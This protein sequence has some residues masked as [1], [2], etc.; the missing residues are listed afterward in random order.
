MRFPLPARA[1]GWLHDLAPRPVVLSCPYPVDECVRLLSVA[2]TDRGRVSW[3]LDPRTAVQP[4]PRFF[5]KAGPSGVCLARHE[6]FDRR[7]STPAWLSAQLE[8]AADG[9][10]NLAGTIGRNPAEGRREPLLFLILGLAGA[11]A[12]VVGS[13]ALAHGRFGG[14]VAI[15]VLPLAL[16]G[17]AVLHLTA[18][19]DSLSRSAASLVEELNKVLNSTAPG[20]PPPTPSP[21]AN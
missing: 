5:G 12:I 14:L 16:P 18:M 15:V 7:Y 4:E 11:V 13:V 3:Y 1:R 2:T 10:T 17:L 6:D 19:R 9:G 21:N 20:R 8:P